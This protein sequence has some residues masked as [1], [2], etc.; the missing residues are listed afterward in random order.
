MVGPSRCW[1]RGRPRVRLAT[2]TKPVMSTETASENGTVA[3]IV[4]PTGSGKSAIAMERARVDPSIEIVAV[5]AFTIYRGMDIGTAKPT[6][7][8]RA[9]VPHHL[10]DIRTPDQTITVAD[11]QSLARAA[12]AEVAARGRQ[13]L[14]V[15][16]SGL[17]FRAVVDP[18][19]FPPTDADVRADLEAT[20]SA[21]GA[22]AAHCHLTD[23]DPDAASRIESENMR[24]TIRA[25]E[26]IAITG[27]PFS[28]FR[29]DWEA[30]QSIYRRLSVTYVDLPR[31]VLRARIR[32][33]TERLVAGG[34][35]DEAAALRLAWPDGLSVT[36][37]KAIGYAEAFDVLDGRLAP[38]DLVDTVARRT[39]QYARRQRSWF[40]RDPRCVAQA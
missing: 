14:L 30:H 22:A 27:R 9:D 18:L 16:G 23:V 25:L 29:T 13:P 36:A 33:R 32:R 21:R 3:A 10:I 37:A 12:I 8:E 11:F 24:R 20:W 26:V 35:V 15:G 6:P 7:T 17:Y 4:G 2:V 19:D 5:D 38:D 40:R 34:L 39:W 28:D 31:D 1:G